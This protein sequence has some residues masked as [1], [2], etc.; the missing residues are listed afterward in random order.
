MTGRQHPYSRRRGPKMSEEI[1]IEGEPDGGPFCEL[2]RL[3]L[4]F[5]EDIEDETRK[6]E[7]V[8]VWSACLAAAVGAP[9]DKIRSSAAQIKDGVFTGLSGVASLSRKK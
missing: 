3:Y 9:H 2:F 7:R 5:I 1:E 8:Y 6:Q 4:D